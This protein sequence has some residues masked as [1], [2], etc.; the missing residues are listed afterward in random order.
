MVTMTLDLG[1]ELSAMGLLKILG[2][3]LPNSV[4]SFISKH[5]LGRFLYFP[6]SQS[7]F[8]PMPDTLSQSSQGPLPSRDQ[9]REA[10]GLGELGQL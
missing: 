3:V 4:P 5:H 8:S 6:V 7:P 2:K 10:K 9:E 1:L